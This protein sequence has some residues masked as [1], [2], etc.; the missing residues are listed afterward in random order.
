MKDQRHRLCLWTRIR[1]NQ[2]TKLYDLIISCSKSHSITRSQDDPHRISSLRSQEQAGSFV[3]E[4]SPDC[5]L[6]MVMAD[7]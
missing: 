7:F 1:G 6:T 2:K 4:L 3:A 5:V